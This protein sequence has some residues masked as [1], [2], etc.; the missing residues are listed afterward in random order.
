MIQIAVCDDESALCSLL[1]EKLTALLNSQE[2]PFSITCCTSSSELL[3]TSTPY[4]LIFLDICM[5]GFDGMETARLLRKRLPDSVLIFITIL[6][7]YMQKAFEV[8]AF[9]YLCKPMDDGRLA[10]TLER[11]LKRLSRRKEPHLLIRTSNHCCSIGLS[12]I[13]YCEV[14]NRKLYLHT[15]EGI[16]EYYGKMEELVTQLDSRFFR[17]HRSYLINLDYFKSY[18]KGQICLQDGSCI[19]ISRLRHREFMDVMME[20]VSRSHSIH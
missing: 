15:Q 12:A 3:N 13:F 17:C 14:I 5:P 8:E 2:E 19:P 11:A 18:S 4:D 6:T 10:C 16:L 9:D 7:D 1:K 20:Y